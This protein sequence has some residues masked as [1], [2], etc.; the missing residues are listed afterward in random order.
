[1]LCSPAERGGTENVR[2]RVKRRPRF[3]R[4]YA[5]TSVRETL[6][7]SQRYVRRAGFTTAAP[8]VRK[9]ASPVI[10]RTV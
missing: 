4:V 3:A 9:C 1:M 10:R 8:N 7:A 5:P 2:S 6:C